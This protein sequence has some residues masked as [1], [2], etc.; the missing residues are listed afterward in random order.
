[1]KDAHPEVA[2]EIKTTKQ[3][4]DAAKKTLDQAVATVKAEFA[5]TAAPAAAAKK[6]PAA[7]A[8]PAAAAK[9]H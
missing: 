5:A 2:E 9:K 6:A 1:M 4:S 8:A 7:P 3:V